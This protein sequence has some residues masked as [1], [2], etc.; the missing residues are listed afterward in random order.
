[1]SK[2]ERSLGAANPS[3]CFPKEGLGVF[4][5]KMESVLGLPVLLSEDTAHTADS[6]FVIL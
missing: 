6:L 4:A 1:M 2:S 3:K 5:A